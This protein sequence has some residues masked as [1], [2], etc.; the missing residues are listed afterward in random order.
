MGKIHILADSRSRKE[1]RRMRQLQIIDST[2]ITS[3]SNLLSKGSGRCP[4]NWKK[5]EKMKVHTVIYTNDGVR[6]MSFVEQT[7]KYCE[8]LSEGEQSML[9]YRCG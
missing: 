2:A 6:H 8:I 9:N 7:D 1:P 4:K 5:K 3:F